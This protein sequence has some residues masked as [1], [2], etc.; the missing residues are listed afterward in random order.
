MRPVRVAG[1][2][3]VRV[4]VGRGAVV[5][6]AGRRE[7]G[8]PALLALDVG[9]DFADVGGRLAQDVGVVTLRG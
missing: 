8:D 4:A 7:A 1:R 2:L 5:E 9:A 6:A 3:E